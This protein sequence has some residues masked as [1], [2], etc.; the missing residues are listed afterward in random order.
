MATIT[1]NTAPVLKDLT[2]DDLT[3]HVIDISTENAPNERT[4]DLLSGLI[5]HVHDYV[6]E[7]RMT[8]A[9]WEIGNGLEILH[10]RKK[11]KKYQVLFRQFSTNL[12][13]I[14]GRTELYG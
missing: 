4:K 11:S 1:A 2:A 9:E 12:C 13:G 5:K 3:Q 6:R 7:V 10:G 14:S 8:P